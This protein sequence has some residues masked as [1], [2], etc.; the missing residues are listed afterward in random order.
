MDPSTLSPLR[1][2]HSESS[3]AP[4]PSASQPRPQVQFAAGTKAPHLPPPASLFGSKSEPTLS[5]S[6]PSPSQRK[7]HP[8]LDTLEDNTPHTYN[9]IMLAAETL[10]NIVN[11]GTFV[12][13]IRARFKLY[14]KQP[15]VEH[16]GREM[17]DRVLKL[18]LNNL[19]LVKVLLYDLM[20]YHFNYHHYPGVCYETPKNTKSDDLQYQ[21][22]TAELVKDL[23]TSLRSFQVKLGAA[24][25]RLRIEKRASGDTTREQMENILPLDVREK[26]IMAVEM[27]KTLKVNTLRS[28]TDEVARKLEGLGYRVMLKPLASIPREIT[29]RYGADL[30]YL[31]EDFDDLF[32]IPPKFFAEIKAGPLVSEG[33]LVF[34]DKASVY[35]P[36]HLQ[37]LL[38]AGSQVI[39]A[40][41]G[42]GTKTAALSA[43]VGKPGAIYAFENRTGRLDTLKSNIRLYGCENR[44][45]TVLTQDADV[46]IV[47]NDFSISDVHD[48]RFA[49]VTAVIVE[50]PNSGTAIVDKLGFMLQEEEFPNDQYSLK[51]IYSLKHQQIATL[52]HAFKFPSV[53]VVMY[54]TRSTHTEEN[55]QV[56]QETLDRYGV[57]WELSCVLPS[58]VVDHL[59]SYEMDECLTVRPSEQAGNGIFIACFQRKQPERN[60]SGDDGDKDEC[61]EGVARRM[62]DLSISELDQRQQHADGS[63]ARDSKTGKKKRKRSGRR[64]SKIRITAQIKLPRGMSES[65]ERLSVPRFVQLEQKKKK[66]EQLER[67]HADRR[68]AGATGDAGADVDQGPHANANDELD[69]QGVGRNDTRGS[70]IRSGMRS[71]GFCSA[72]LQFS[73]ISIFG[74]SLSK[75]Y[76][77]RMEAMK[78]LQAEEAAG[79]WSYPVNSPRVWHRLVKAVADAFMIDSGAGA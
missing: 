17:S 28:S 79:R 10:E 22:D 5:S 30:I 48:A 13:S 61:A 64:G 35:G 44:N 16:A 9:E 40:R 19:G 63:V 23:D 31:D 34:Q 62:S 57:E 20:K 4:G 54:V 75:F 47:E 67:K 70:V 65:V 27:P 3:I 14:A 49:N 38:P 37:A 60:E 25:A 74:V 71:S 69:M 7:S 8:L 45:A 66:L 56:V 32:V 72:D 73:D 55:E 68:A 33:L 77:P 41:A 6:S 51:D 46:T 2:F 24:Y 21:S 42:C 52:K 26:E 53:K 78:R 59:N 50:P 18:F 11:E 43:L 58:I 36:K 1:A 29:Q 15:D 39:D 12:G 76:G